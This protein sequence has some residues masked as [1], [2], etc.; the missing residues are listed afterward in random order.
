MSSA[1]AAL[2][3][4][5]RAVQTDVV[6]LAALVNVAYRGDSS[7]A[8]W[9]TEA[10]LL[11]GQRTDP[12]Q[13]RRAIDQPGQVIL[14]ATDAHG[15]LA[16]VLLE[17]RGATCYLGMLT[18]RPTAQRGG[19]GAALLAQAEAWA[20]AEWRVASVTMSVIIQRPELLA[21]YQRRGYVV[22]GERMPFPADDPSFGLP[23]QD[24]LAF[25]VLRKVLPAT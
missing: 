12:E 13:L 16:C 10:D 24:G 9:T 21:W 1:V 8:G 20:A 2:P 14:M 25:A 17:H 22:T 5:R 19:L 6:A 23:K 7:R 15:P 18:V 4:L 11:G 3:P